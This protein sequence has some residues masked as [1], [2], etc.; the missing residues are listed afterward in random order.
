MVISKLIILL[1]VPLF[2]AEMV[3]NPPP[4]PKKKKE[5]YAPCD[6]DSENHVNKN[7]NFRN[8]SQFIVNTSGGKYC[9]R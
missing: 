5:M 6:S 2:L 4:P 1:R 7:N 8:F 9:N 3:E